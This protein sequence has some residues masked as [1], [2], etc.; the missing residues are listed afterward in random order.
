MMEMYAIKDELDGFTTPIPFG[1]E[2]IAIRW[3]LTMQETNV[4]MNHNKEN[5]SLWYMGTFNKNTG[6]YNADLKEVNI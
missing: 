6:E 1:N 4:D 5:F 2:K 3:Y